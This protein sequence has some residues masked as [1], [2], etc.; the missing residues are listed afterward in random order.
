MGRLLILLAI[1]IVIAIIVYL[2]RE[3]AKAAAQQELAG[4]QRRQLATPARETPPLAATVPPTAP[5]AEAAR[6]R[7][8]SG[9]LQGAAD[10]AS[11]KNYEKATERL[12]E[13]ST[14]L[15]QARHDAEQAAERLAS[16]AGEALSAVLI[17]AKGDA[18]P[19]DGT[20]E[21]PA[22]YPV[23]GMIPSLG[24]HEPGDPAY[25]LTVAEVCFESAAAAEATGFT[26]AREMSGLAGAGLAARE[27]VKVVAERPRARE[28]VEVVEVVEAGVPP[29]AVLGDGGRD[30]PPA[31]SIKAS[32]VSRRYL[33]PDA[34]AYAMTI[35]ELCFSSVEA[36]AA[37]GLAPAER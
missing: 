24:Y 27:P 15:T 6:A 17:A 32:R 7:P 20:R 5:A 16:A 4:R 8:R 11:G 21:C 25:A 1:I 26:P 23:K 33:E 19:G 36:A 34:P 9:L 30:C 37:A 2:R 31:Y 12:Q 22:G 13:L 3:N 10:A 28:R 29:G 18:V 14:E 35:P